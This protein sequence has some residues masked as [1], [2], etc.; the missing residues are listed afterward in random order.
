MFSEAQST[1]ELLVRH[2]R[3][4]E[5]SLKYMGTPCSTHDAFRD[6]NGIDGDTL[7]HT[8]LDCQEG[9]VFDVLR[10]PEYRGTPSST[11]EALSDVNSPDNH[12]RP[13]L[14]I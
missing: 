12:N 11:D 14:W 5:T 10:S 3:L 2:T 9:I 4:S 7:H 6:V 13:T 8:T 1:C